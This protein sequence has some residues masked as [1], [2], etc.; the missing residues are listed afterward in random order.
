MTLGVD[1]VEEE[2]FPED[3]EGKETLTLRRYLIIRFNYKIFSFKNVLHAHEK[4]KIEKYFYSKASSIS[5]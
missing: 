1:S 4:E 5:K 2:T 3:N